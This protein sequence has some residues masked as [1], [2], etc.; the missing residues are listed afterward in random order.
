M[1]IRDL[2]KEHATFHKERVSALTPDTQRLW[3]EMEVSRMMR[4]LRVTIELSLDDPDGQVKV[5]APPVIRTIV[6]WIFF[7]IFTTWPKGKLKS[8]PLFTPESVETFAEEQRMLLEAIERYGDRFEAN[9]NEKRLHPLLG[10]VTLRRW[11]HAHGVHMNHHY[12]QFGLVRGCVV[13]VSGFPRCHGTVR[14]P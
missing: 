14:R 10:L 11:A 3:G 6:G 4:H 9:P 8:L 13:C 1:A 2:T 7:D 12:R 5:I